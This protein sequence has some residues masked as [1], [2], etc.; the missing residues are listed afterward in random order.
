MTSEAL[1]LQSNSPRSAQSVLADL[2]TIWKAVLEVDAVTEDDNFF[3][4][5]GDSL[6]AA[7]LMVHIE[8]T[9]GLLIDPIEI[10][11]HPVLSEFAALIACEQAASAME[12]GV[13]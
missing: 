7:A 1:A 12:D 8:E 2:T 3:M 4:L 11:E 6:K 13:L 5:G 9:F 10:F